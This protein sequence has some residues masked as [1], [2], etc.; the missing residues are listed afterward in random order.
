[1]FLQLR[2]Y[3]EDFRKE[4]Q[5]KDRLR[6][7]LN[8]HR[9]VRSTSSSTRDEAGITNNHFILYQQGVDQDTTLNE[10]TRKAQAVAERQARLRALRDQ[11]KR[12]ERH[13]LQD[14]QEL[15]QHTLVMSIHPEAQQSV[16][17]P[18]YV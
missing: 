8:S 18:G 3:E 5:E 17:I 7:Q 11:Y 1:L 9:E 16:R 2:L 10:M 4:S 14:Q 12:E 15:Q 13:L 6:R